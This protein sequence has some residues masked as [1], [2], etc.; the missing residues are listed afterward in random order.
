MLTFPSQELLPYLSKSCF[1]R[2]KER[3]LLVPAYFIGLYFHRSNDPV[4]TVLIAK[5]FCLGLKVFWSKVGTM[6]AL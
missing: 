5:G 2:V 6:G 1:R 3:Q 4:F